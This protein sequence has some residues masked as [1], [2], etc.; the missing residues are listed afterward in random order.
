MFADDVSLFNSH[1]NKEVAEAA[2]QEAITNVAEWSRCRKLTLN[3]SK[4]EVAFFTNNS[5]EA[6][7]QSSVQLDGTT[8]NTTSLPKFLGVTIDRALSFGPHVTGVVSKASNRFRVLVSITTK[9]WGWRKDQLLKVFRALHLS[10]I[11]YAGPAWQPWLAPTRLDQLE[12][13]QNRALHII[14][15]QLKTTPL[16]ALRIEAG[17]P[18]IATQAHQQ[19][20]VPYEKAHRHPPNHP[21]I[22]LLKEP[23]R[24]R[25]KRPS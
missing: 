16:E 3:S 18:S 23:C 24:H 5:K 21:R 7:L 13:C 17:V 10:V 11:N 14:T 19:V 6:R 15:G 22:A 25:L 12:R 2:I 1:P 4:C 9:R 8:L 20:S